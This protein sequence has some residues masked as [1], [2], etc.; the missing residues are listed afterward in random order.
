MLHDWNVELH[1]SRAK[2]IV[3]FNAEADFLE[4]EGRKKSCND[5]DF[6]IDENTHL[7][8]THQRFKDGNEKDV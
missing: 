2:R 8:T 6:I 7:S 5:F 1:S 3:A 4:E